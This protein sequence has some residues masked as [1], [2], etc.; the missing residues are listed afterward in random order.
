MHVVLCYCTQAWSDSV[1]HL[2]GRMKKSKTS[3][4]GIE[5]C[6]TALS[7]ALSQLSQA[8]QQARQ[9]LEGSLHSVLQWQQGQLQSLLEKYVGGDAQ[10]LWAWQHSQA[11]DA[12]CVLKAM[13][14]EQGALLQGLTDMCSRGKKAAKKK[15]GSAGGLSE[16]EDLDG[17]NWN[18]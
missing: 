6:S 10:Q 1:L 9:Q 5:A 15:A 2:Q 16:R 3:A 14:Q 11:F 8:H 18:Y 7:A 4:Q 13:A 12:R 17:H